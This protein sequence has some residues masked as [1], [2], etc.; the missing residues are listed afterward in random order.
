MVSTSFSLRSQSREPAL[1]R[2]EAYLAEAQRLSHTGSWAYL[3]STGESTYWSEE[4]FRIFGRDPDTAPPTGEAFWELIH[5]DDRS[6]LQGAMQKA[7]REKVGCLFDY[8]ILLP[9][10]VLKHIHSVTHVV[11]SSSGEVVEMLGTAVD[12]TERK[13][14]EEA[15]RRSEE[16]FHN[17]LE[18]MPA[19]AFIAQPDGSNEFQSRGWLEYSGLSQEASTG[20]GWTAAVHP[21]DLEKHVGRWRSSL[22]SGELFE[23][24]VRHRN[25]KGEYRWFLTRAV[26]LRDE[27]GK[28][29]KW[30]GIATDIDDRKRAE[31]ELKAALSQV[32]TLRD[33][34]VHENIAL[35]DEIDTASMFEDIIGHSPTL[36]RVLSRVI[37]IAPT[38]STVLITGET[39]TG[40]ELFARAIHK[41][42]HRSSRAFVAV[43]CASIPSALIASE[44][45]GYEKGAFT[46]AQQR[47]PGRFELADGGT[48]FLDEVGELP[49]ETQIALLRVLQER[50]FERVGGT[51]TIRC[52]VRVL[53][54]TNGDLEAAVADGAFRADLFYRLNVV[55]LELPP[56]RDRKSDI[57]TL[58]EY[59]IGRY[60]RRA[61]KKIRAVDRNSLERLQAYSWPGNIR[62][63]QN[64]VE[65]SV[66]LCETDQ[67]SVD[68]GWLSGD[69]AA[70]KSIET[71]LP[72]R[73]NAQEKK[74]ITS[75]LSESNGKVSGP[76]GAAELLGIPPSTLE[77]RIR[78]LRINKFAF[79]KS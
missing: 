19:I 28:I 59:F 41:R 40:K 8:R 63:L 57:P 23:D 70:W 60:A 48:I 17:L 52:D 39:G 9:D 25:A 42:S 47:R 58:V 33:R 30:Y 50:E 55:P 75:A 74:R 62:E 65:R 1:R 53:A 71:T 2:S 29:L 6:G 37:K 46:G 36:R 72:R 18:R 27:H 44:L 69:G 51:Q 54:A 76:A 61:G 79:K 10:G 78:A 3:P 11:V 68:P 24:E 4:L 26:P 20:H 7:L 21:Q 56:L 22:L 32:K 49:L 34:L 73:S 77:S 45:F 13:G 43:N 64:I 12:V 16:E 5:P 35:R 14:A 66:I 67:F 31:E 38:D 15:L